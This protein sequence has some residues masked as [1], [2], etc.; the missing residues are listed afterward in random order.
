MPGTRLSKSPIA[1]PPR[2]ALSGRP[3]RA[4]HQ[5][6]GQ[7]S[8]GI[9]DPG[10]SVSEV[11]ATQSREQAEHGSSEIDKNARI[12]Y[13]EKDMAMM[14]E[15]F[16]KELDQLGQKL[17]NE[18]EISAYWQQ[19]HSALN[20]QFLKTDTD[21]RMLR[22]EIATRDKQREERD[23]DVKTRISSLVLDRDGLKDA[24]HFAKTELARR[25]EEIQQ[26]R[27]QVKALKDFV[28]TNSRT[29]GQVT[30]EVF[31]EMMQ[32]LGNGL[33]N[34]VIQNFR[35]A[36]IGKGP[37]TGAYIM[38]TTI[39]RSYKGQGRHQRTA[40]TTRTYVRESSSFSENTPYTI[41][42]LTG[43]SH[44]DIQELLRRTSRRPV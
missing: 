11:E 39:F 44:L 14:E 40:T 5:G 16:S 36:K 41:R 7:T 32:K 29:D 20:Q 38:L 12:A 30:D 2:V 43:V 22:H 8:E 4:D 26:L 18:S 37:T 28:S 10:A 6:D 17:T 1:P 13:L 27:T 31:G 3:A 15:E 21:L 35:R 34:W 19:K 42:H 23:R 24:Y 33:Q 9:S 25:E